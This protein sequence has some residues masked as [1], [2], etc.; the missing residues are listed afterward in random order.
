[1]ATTVAPVKPL[2]VTV[3][4]SP[5]CTPPTDGETPDTTGDDE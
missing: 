4:M 5:P 2:P 3:A 1:M